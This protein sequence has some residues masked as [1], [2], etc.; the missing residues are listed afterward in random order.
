MPSLKR[1]R[2]VVLLKPRVREH[3]RKIITKPTL[4]IVHSLGNSAEKFFQTICG[5]VVWCTLCVSQPVAQGKDYA[6]NLLRS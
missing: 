5:H 1:L 6:K 4:K 2:F 3:D